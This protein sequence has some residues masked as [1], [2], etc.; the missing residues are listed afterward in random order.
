MLR[1]GNCRISCGGADHAVDRGK[2]DPD[3]VVLRSKG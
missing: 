3:A 1:G 2:T